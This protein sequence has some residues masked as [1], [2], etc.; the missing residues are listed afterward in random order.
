[1]ELRV[2]VL[3]LQ[4]WGISSLT[5]IDQQLPFFLLLLFAMTPHDFYS[6]NP[7]IGLCWWLSDKE[8]TCQC[9]RCR[10]DRWVR[11]IPWRRAWQP[12]Q[13]FLPGE[14]RGQGSL[15]GY[16]PWGHKELETT[17]HWCHSHINDL[18]RSEYS[19]YY[20]GIFR[21]VIMSETLPRTI[22]SPFTSAGILKEQ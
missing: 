18:E 17:E 2:R 10:F 15:A 9:K 8:S 7:S 5:L 13:V 21:N 1:M 20:L 6:P 19:F 12:T 4:L 11:K 16:R 3:A 22:G 14:S